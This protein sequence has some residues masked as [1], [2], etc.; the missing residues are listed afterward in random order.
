MKMTVLGLRRKQGVFEGK[1]YDNFM[2]Y[3]AIDNP[4]DTTMIAGTDVESFKIK[5]DDFLMACA[6]NIQALGNPKITAAKD[7]IGLLFSPA[8]SKIQGVT[9]DF[10]L[11]LPEKEK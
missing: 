8:Y 4:A 9:T 6:R 3:V 5:S 7:F 11:A 2:I 1:P 10:V